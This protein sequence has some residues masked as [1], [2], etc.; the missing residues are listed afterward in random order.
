MVG[1]RLC[2]GGGVDAL[3]F[4]SDI[5][6]RRCGDAA[7]CVIIRDDM[8]GDAWERRDARWGDAWERRDAPWGDAAAWYGDD[9]SMLSD[10]TEW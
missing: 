8:C 7:A 4:L 3:P 6:T 2:I 9:T 5:C 1:V 10:N